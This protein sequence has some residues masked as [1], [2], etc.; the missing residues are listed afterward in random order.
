M[1]DEAGP[2][3]AL[4][5]EVREW[6][7][8]SR[9]R[10]VLT[11][12]D[13]TLLASHEVDLDRAT[14]SRSEEWEAFT[15]LEKFLRWRASPD[16][17]LD[18]E[19]E[20]LAQ[21]GEWITDQALGVG[22]ARELVRWP[23]P[24]RVVIPPQAQVL[25]YLPWQAAWVEGQTL[26]GSKVTLVT[27]PF[28]RPLTTKRPVADRLRMLAVFSLPEGTGALNLRRERYALARLLNK[29]AK[30]NG[31][32]VQLQVVQYGATRQRLK[33]ALLDSEGWDVLH[34]SGHGL[35]AG[36]VLEDDTG[37]R[38]VVTTAE[39]VDL[40]E[41][42]SARLKLINLF[43]C[44][45]AA[46]TAE[47]HL[48]LLGLTPADD[49]DQ[50]QSLGE[51]QRQDH[52][53]GQG[54]GEAPSRDGVI[55]RL[56]VLATALVDRVG[57]AVLAMRYPVVDDFALGLSEQ[58]YDLVLARGQPV[59]EAL[60]LA[61]QQVVPT[62]PTAGV[63]ALSVATP[64]L[65][66]ARALDLR[67]QAPDGE[68]TGLKEQRQKLT[69]FPDQPGR[70]VGRVAAMARTA[71]V[72]APRS[73]AAG[74][75]FHG[76]AGAG[77][78]A[79]ALELAY[80]HQDSFKWLVW[81]QGPLQEQDVAIAF[82]ALA[83]DL[84]AQIPGL[85][86]VHLVD[87]RAS[88]AGFLPALTEFLQNNRVL[89]VLDSLEWLL[90]ST[91][92]WRDERWPLL[93]GA[94]AVPSGLSRLLVTSR[95]VPAK[96]P[97]GLRL[98]PVHGLSLRESVLLA[99]E[100][101][102]LQALIDS[103]TS[104][105][106][107][108]G[109]G[110]GLAVRVLK[111]VQGHPKLIELAEGQAADP[112][113]LAARL[114][115][116][117]QTWLSRGVWLQAFLENGQSPAADEDFYQVLDA[118]TR[119]AARQLP[120]PSAVLFNVLA[121]LEDNDRIPGI[122]EVIWSQVWK[123]LGHPD[124]APA[125]EDV[126]RPLLTQALVAAEHDPRTGE[127]TRYRIHPGIA[128]AARAHTPHDTSELI[129]NAAAAAWH[130]VLV[131]GLEHETEGQGGLVPYAARSEAPYLTR[132][133]YWTTLAE[134]LER[135][136]ERDR[137][138]AAAA[139]LLP[140]LQAAADASVG[141]D[142]EILCGS[143]YARALSV[144][145]P[146]Q[147][148]HELHRLHQLA[149]ARGGHTAAAGIAGDLADYY[150]DTGRY[151]EALTVLNQ[152]QQDVRR[153]GL[154]LWSQVSVEGRRL[155]VRRRQGHYQEVLE[156]V[157]RLQDLMA[158]LSDSPDQRE[159]V[160]PWSTRELVLNSGMAAAA[161]LG[162]LQRSLDF[163]TETI[164]SML[165]RGAADWQLA[166]ARF[167]E[168]GLLRDLGRLEQARALLLICREVFE[169]HRD[170]PM[171]GSTLSA[172]AHIEDELGHGHA[173]IRLQRDGLRLA[174]AGT[175]IDTTAASHNNL[176]NALDR[177]PQYAGEVWAHR[178]AAA[179]IAYQTSSGHFSGALANL[180]RMASR[181]DMPA[182]P[183]S[184]EQVCQIVDQTEGV[185][186]AA[187]I[188][189]LPARAADGPT[190]LTDIL[191]YTGQL[192]QRHAERDRHL[193]NWEPVISAMTAAIPPPDSDAPDTGSYL[194]Q[195]AAQHL[196]QALDRYAATRDWANLATALRRIHTGERDFATLTTD[197]DHIDTAIVHRTLTALDG[198]NPIDPTLWTTDASSDDDSEGHRWQAFAADV[199]AAANGDPVA[200][201]A[202]SPALNQ[203]AD[204]PHTAALAGAL[205]AIQAGD[206]DPTRLKTGLG[207]GAQP[208]I[209][210][211][212][213][214]LTE[215]DSP[216]ND[217]STAPAERDT[218]P[219]ASNTADDQGKADELPTD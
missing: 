32:A 89:L 131:Q 177:Y 81:H 176:A 164:A 192:T 84:E 114:D 58:F 173:A 2:R 166:R 44:E 22:I 6:V 30:V 215:H 16:R 121:G 135:S 117:D 169:A 59:P 167:N 147:G 1:P 172:L 148:M 54:A 168:C 91:G 175:D 109:S 96:L 140:F 142:Q 163:N 139:A 170:I 70:F 183:D 186:L 133:G 28:D 101:P 77:K 63:P 3:A 138:P 17:R 205:R 193:Q 36:L 190:A 26:A 73:G 174:Y 201:A 143:M 50:E 128:E 78:T 116:I 197:L 206:R 123:G 195:A 35:P 209:T 20:L 111:M 51:D 27:D 120:G 153:A 21:V 210:A 149:R 107:D 203:L 105:Q 98:E 38:D 130:F 46:L 137:S 95:I 126:V 187:L 14:A 99:R 214:A 34:L 97:G 202:I 82:T 93:L 212:L 53:Q 18:D 156:S 64:A 4:R 74:V 217:P 144:L 75:V 13:G 9:W 90:T 216:A 106:P 15:D 171:L 102:N 55:G 151:E 100:W 159:N 83:Q 119:A 25:A 146:E 184:Y 88:L 23:G 10:W 154:G 52:A 152:M 12:P 92:Q 165:A 132:R 110:R 31:R 67:L 198:T 125:V 48:R 56:S 162:L 11:G 180:V 141:T 157:E 69:R 118:W 196:T 76:M 66:G 79:C 185:H 145:R 200:A 181:A 60:G 68:P 194:R 7:S 94:F 40:I 155:H 41:A 19:A 189:R 213:A 211:I 204:K 42:G 219:P 115:E 136:L 134:V 129:D 80:T 65:F 71:A 122:L 113:G 37:R 47:E 112:A 104:G 5:L 57:A 87:D 49:T 178:L 61:M 199:V 103:P 188:A 182:P 24:V 127:L 85:E 150:R 86:L 124:P 29:I 39:L 72:L 218:P 208:L 158:S 161:E 108:P 43:A 45:S 62:E 191:N 8:P 33:D 160:T 207:A 179:L